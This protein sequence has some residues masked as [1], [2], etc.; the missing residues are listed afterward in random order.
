MLGVLPSRCSYFSWKDQHSNYYVSVMIEL[1]TH[2]EMECYL[3]LEMVGV[4]EI[5]SVVMIPERNF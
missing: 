4:L 1:S 2:K 5:S 3:D